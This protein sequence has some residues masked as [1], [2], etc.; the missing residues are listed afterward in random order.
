ML[1]FGGLEMKGFLKI[2]L[3]ILVLSVV[4]VFAI[5]GICC[6]TVNDIKNTAK[7]QF[8]ESDPVV[9]EQ[10]AKSIV[11][12]TLP[13]GYNLFKAFDFYGAKGAIFMYLPKAQ[14]L[15]V[16]SPGGI[17]KYI[18]RIDE[19]NFKQELSQEK[20]ETAMQQ[21]SSSSVE[22]KEFKILNEGMLPTATREIPYIMGKIVFQKRATGEEMQYE[23]AVSVFTTSDNKNIIILSANKPGMFD[24]DATKAFI[25][26]VEVK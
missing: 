26:T 4:A 15:F 1:A 24:F 22:I 12:Y 18:F 16:G 7:T 13:K 17:A 8:Q 6:F 11:N 23:G 10:R 14:F 19:K 3:I 25:K 5:G 2:F 21:N 20:I 9:M